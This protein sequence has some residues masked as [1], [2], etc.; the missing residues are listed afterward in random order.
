MDKQSSRQWSVDQLE[1]DMK[2]L[3]LIVDIGDPKV[4]HIEDN[5]AFVGDRYI[6]SLEERTAVT[7]NEH[8]AQQAASLVECE[9]INKNLLETIEILRAQNKQL[10]KT[11]RE[12]QQTISALTAWVPHSEV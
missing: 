2:E 12:I 7:P 6:G 8:L 1:E 4:K 3:G 5:L 9:K 10:R 11:L